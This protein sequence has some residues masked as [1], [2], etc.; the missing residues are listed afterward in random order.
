[1]NYMEDGPL[2]PP[3]IDPCE[4]HPHYA[5]RDCPECLSIWE[6]HQEDLMDEMRLERR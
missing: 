3:V 1:M 6:Q 2:E 5:E 4:W